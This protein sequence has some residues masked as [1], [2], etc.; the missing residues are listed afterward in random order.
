[1][2]GPPKRS[3]P[4]RG[5]SDPAAAQ[6]RG[7]AFRIRSH[8]SGDVP[9]KDWVWCEAIHSVDVNCFTGSLLLGLYNRSERSNA[10]M[11]WWKRLWEQLWGTHSRQT[12][13]ANEPAWVLLHWSAVPE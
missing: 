11:N 6:G 13:A 8:I 2:A 9:R 10:E 4:K 7:I 12:V 5:R 3:S 1:M